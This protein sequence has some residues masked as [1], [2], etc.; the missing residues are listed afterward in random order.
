MDEISRLARR[1]RLTVGDWVRRVLR[2]ASVQQHVREPQ[3]KLKAVRRAAKYSFPAG[4][5]EQML[6]EIGRGYQ[7]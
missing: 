6:A 1:E 7:K 5:I 3:L 4:G 2:Q